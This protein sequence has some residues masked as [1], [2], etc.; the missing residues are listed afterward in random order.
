MLEEGEKENGREREANKNQARWPERTAPGKYD[1]WGSSHQLFHILVV[2]AATTHFYGLVIAFDYH[3][4][5]DIEVC[6]T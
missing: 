5:G 3:H 2:M 1:I 6:K 4:G